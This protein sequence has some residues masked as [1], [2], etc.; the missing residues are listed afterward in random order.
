MTTNRWRA[1]VY[2]PTPVAVYRNRVDVVDRVVRF[3][4]TWSPVEITGRFL[5]ARLRF[6]HITPSGP[7]KNSKRPSVRNVRL[8]NVTLI[9][10]FS[11]WISFRA[12]R[13]FPTGT[14]LENIVCVCVCVCVLLFWRDVLRLTDGWRTVDAGAGEIVLATVVAYN[15]TF[16]L[17]QNTM[18][19]SNRNCQIRRTNRSRV[20]RKHCVLACLSNFF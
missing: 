3:V 1:N 10:R 12:R 17:A 8:F 4:P 16:R 14:R 11:S 20:F 6:A 5:S 19:V 13:S 2:T 15:R 18:F 9:D 7:V